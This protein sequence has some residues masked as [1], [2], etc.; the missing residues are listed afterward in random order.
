MGCWRYPGLL[1]HLFCVSTAVGAPPRPPAASGMYANPVPSLC[2]GLCSRGAGRAAAAVTAASHTAL[3]L[4]DS[5]PTPL[6]VPQP[7][8]WLSLSGNGWKPWRRSGG[9]GRRARRGPART[10]RERRAA[11]AL[12]PWM[13]L[14][15]RCRRAAMLHG[16]QSGPGPRSA[17]SGGWAGEP[18]VMHWRMIGPPAATARAAVS[19]AVWRQ[20][21]CCGWGGRRSCTQ[22]LDG[23]EHGVAH[24]ELAR[25]VAAVYRMH[26]LTWHLLHW[27]ACPCRPQ[28]RGRLK[29]R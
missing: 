18:L 28:R 19:G 5:V 22:H 27:H 6:L 15:A 13:P 9:G 26:K 23:A 11:L 20:C 1:L 17:A 24:A 21:M 7:R 25:C 16:V 12:G 29:W 2:Y 3:H 10:K 8:S 14:A 4:L